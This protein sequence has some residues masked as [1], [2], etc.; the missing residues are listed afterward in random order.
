MLKN[1]NYNYWLSSTSDLQP[2]IPIANQSLGKSVSTYL[3]YNDA[4]T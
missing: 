4:T 1:E 2:S 3:N